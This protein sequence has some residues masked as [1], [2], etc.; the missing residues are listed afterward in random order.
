MAIIKQ[1]NTIPWKSNEEWEQVLLTIKN[2]ERQYDKQPLFFYDLAVQIKEK[3]DSL[4][5]TMEDL[6]KK[7]CP[8]CKD[9]CCNR[10][11]IWYDFKDLL[12]IAFSKQKL[13]DFQIRKTYKPKDEKGCCHLSIHG[14]KLKR[15]ERPFVCTWYICPAQKKYLG[16][17]N[18]ELAKEFNSILSKIKKLRQKIETRFIHTVG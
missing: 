10:A 18:P 1:S 6:C 15:S 7:V 5:A 3:I 9:I 12:F 17:N 4:S 14:C 2:F 8:D 16:S 11:T 13:P